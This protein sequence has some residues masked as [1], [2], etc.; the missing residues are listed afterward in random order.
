MNC[1]KL[2]QIVE[3]KQAIG[4]ANHQQIGFRMEGG[5]VDFGVILHEEVLFGNSPSLRCNNLARFKV[6]LREV[7]PTEKSTIL[8][9]CVD[10][11]GE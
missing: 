9:D 2:W 8:A 1:V 6:L 5:A 7:L 3:P 4:E 10:L 11:F